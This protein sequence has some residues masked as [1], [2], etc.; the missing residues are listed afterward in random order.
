MED[1]SSASNSSL[2]SSRVKATTA[3]RVS[4]PLPQG[5]FGD[6]QVSDEQLEDYHSL[7]RRRLGAVLEDEKRYI[8]RQ[9]H[10]LPCLNPEQWKFVR[11]H[12]RLQ[13]YR[14]RSHGHS[15]GEVAADED[16]DEGMRAVA[17]GQPSV[18]AFGSIPGSVE[19]MLYGFA[20]TTE[21]ELQTTLAFHDPNAD[22]AM[23]RVFEL[24][25]TEDPLHF[26]G[27]K[28]VLSKGSATAVFT[29]RDLCFLQATGVKYDSDGK[30]FGYFVLH[31][32][33]LPECPPFSRS[34]TNVIRGKV[35]FTCVFRE[36][37]P[38]VIRVVSRGIFD[39]SGDL[40]R[41]PMA[42]TMPF[43]TTTFMN[44]LFK[45]MDC[46]EAKKLTLLARRNAATGDSRV[47]LLQLNAPKKRLVCAVCMKRGGIGLLSSVRLRPCRVCG[48]AVCSKCGIKNKRMFLGAE[49]PCSVAMCCPMCILEAQ[50]LTDM[51]PSEPKHAVVADFFLRS[52]RSASCWAARPS[53]VMPGPPTTRSDTLNRG[54]NGKNDPEEQQD[55]TSMAI[56]ESVEGEPHALIDMAT[57][58]TADESWGDRDSTGDWDSVQIR[59]SSSTNGVDNDAFDLQKL[60]ENEEESIP[61]IVEELLKTGGVVDGRREQVELAMRYLQTPGENS[62]ARASISF[63]AYPAIGAPSRGQTAAGERER[64]QRNRTEG[65]AALSKGE[66][67]MQTMRTLQ[68]SAD[69]VYA[70]TRANEQ[71]MLHLQ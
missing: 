32:V 14:R 22:C 18:V 49:R 39:T 57:D 19:D 26:V 5:Y 7:I 53:P 1:S 41:F 11:S 66:E 25:T 61:K 68:S 40:G 30:R 29:P 37:T 63:G 35:F 6:V 23:L 33:E 62:S 36:T 24:A 46:A 38:G 15:L 28:W 58:S 54:G 21:K 48:V 16:F 27:L 20:D 70:M 65:S 69:R 56:L 47:S 45:S 43:T 59:C 44:G 31:S 4:F 12:Q 51:R 2:T 3:S 71:M 34:R 9:T 52:Q 42:Y 17:N 60:D 64:R 55:A 8:E 67:M 13:V 10:H 50:H